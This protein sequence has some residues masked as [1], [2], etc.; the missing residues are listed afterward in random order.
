MSYQRFK[1]GGRVVKC[2]FLAKSVQ[3]LLNKKIKTDFSSKKSAFLGLLMTH[4]RYIF[5]KVSYGKRQK[6]YTLIVI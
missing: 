5:R 1:I 6:S 2:L 3:K 4:E